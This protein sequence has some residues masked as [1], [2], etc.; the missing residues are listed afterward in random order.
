MMCSECGKQFTKRSREKARLSVTHH[1]G[2]MSMCRAAD[3]VPVRCDEAD[4][5]SDHDEPDNLGDNVGESGAKKEKLSSWSVT[6]DSKNISCL[7]DKRV[8]VLR[9]VITA[10]NKII[11]LLMEAL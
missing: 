3:A 10:Q 6:L 7:E 2:A 5:D 1:I 11:E 8:A 9:D 4:A